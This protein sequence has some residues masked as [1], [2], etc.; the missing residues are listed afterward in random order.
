MRLR[1]LIDDLLDLGES[2]SAEQ[3][4]RAE[5]RRLEQ[6][7]ANLLADAARSAPTGTAVT[8]DVRVANP[9]DTVRDEVADTEPGTPGGVPRP[10]A[11][12]LEPGRPV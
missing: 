10:D 9:S 2:K 1:E 7:L 12:A 3:S 4:L 11:G 6:V 5:P 8:V